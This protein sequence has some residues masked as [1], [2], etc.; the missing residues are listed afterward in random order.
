MASLNS[1]NR[2]ERSLPSTQH[3]FRHLSDTQAGDGLGAQKHNTLFTSL[4]ASPPPLTSSL[5]DNMKVG[6]FSVSVLVGDKEVPEVEAGGKSYV[7]A[8]PGQAYTVRVSV[9]RGK[10]GGQDA[11]ESTE[12]GL[13]LLWDILGSPPPASSIFLLLLL[14]PTPDLPSPFHVKNGFNTLLVLSAHVWCRSC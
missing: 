10:T 14:I 6:D 3:Y 13:L 9:E 4:S 12:V 7:L 11:R 2:P 1:L 8:Q 5:T